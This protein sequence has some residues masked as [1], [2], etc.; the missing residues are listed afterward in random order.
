M[1]VV[2]LSSACCIHT[3]KWCNG[4]AEKGLEVHLI[5]QQKPMNDYH[6]NVNFHYL[7]YSGNKGYILNALAVRKKIKELD[8]D[9]INVHYASGYGTLALLAGLKEYIMS[10]WGSDVYDFPKTSALHHFIVNKNLNRASVI[11]STSEVMGQYV[12]NNFNL[13]SGLEIEITPFGVDVNI[14]KA[15]PKLACND[16]VIGTVKTLRPKYGIDDLIRAFAIVKNK[17]YDNLKLKIAG[18]GHQLYELTELVKSLG[19]ENDVEFLGWLENTEVPNLLNELDVYIAPSTL[20][21][22]SFGVA[23]VEASAC[24]LPVIVTRVGG[25]PEV[26]VDNQTGFIVEPGNT[27]QISGAIEKII[28]DKLLAKELGKAGRQNVLNKYEWNFCLER[29]ISVYKKHAKRKFF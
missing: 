23:I 10:V 1:K 17:G 21:S 4:L 16:I 8:P 20:D 3:R 12:Q 28:S 11:C 24:E 7:P 22:E 18:K 2:L 13:R 29:M 14:F 6:K 19:L 25:L 27:Q 9:I 26:V 5:S 15:V